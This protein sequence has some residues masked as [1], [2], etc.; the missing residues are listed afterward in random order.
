MPFFQDPSVEGGRQGACC[1]SQLGVW[2]VP[3]NQASCLTPSYHLSLTES[4]QGAGGL[5]AQ[6]R[7]SLTGGRGESKHHL[8]G[9]AC[10]C[11]SPATWQDHQPAHP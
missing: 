8:R 6:P 3:R 11:R 7:H 2:L 5:R 4:R 9:E 10:V 1:F